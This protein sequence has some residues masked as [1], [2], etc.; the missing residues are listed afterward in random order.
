MLLV[1]I[2]PNE[3]PDKNWNIDCLFSAIIKK[4]EMPVNKNS[5]SG[6]TKADF[7]KNFFC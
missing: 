7:I 2:P 4:T 6:V 3:G 5:L 1:G